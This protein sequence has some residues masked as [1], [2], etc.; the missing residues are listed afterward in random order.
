[1][2]DRERLQSTLLP[3]V[4]QERLELPEDRRVRLGVRPEAL[5]NVFHRISAS[6]DCY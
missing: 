6:L 2:G 5:D 1:M 4:R 3:P